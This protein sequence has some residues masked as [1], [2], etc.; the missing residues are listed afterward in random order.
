MKVNKEKR[1]KGL[2]SLFYA[3]RLLVANPF[4]APESYWMQDFHFYFYIFLLLLHLWYL[5]ISLWIKLVHLPPLPTTE[6]ALKLS[7]YQHLDRSQCHNLLVKQKPLIH[8][9]WYLMMIYK[10]I[11]FFMFQAKHTWFYT[12]LKSQNNCDFP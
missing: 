2:A 8:Q 12:H 7:V 10:L 6:A 9:L 11:W 3:I 4:D 5:M 1:K